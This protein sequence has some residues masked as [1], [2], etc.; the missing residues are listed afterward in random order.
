MGETTNLMIRLDRRTGPI[1]G[2]LSIGDERHEFR[3]WI[4]L[5]G[6]LESLRPPGADRSESPSSDPGASLSRASSEPPGRRGARPA[7]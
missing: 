6:L 3:G 7:S 1:S 4:Q 5:A 2:V